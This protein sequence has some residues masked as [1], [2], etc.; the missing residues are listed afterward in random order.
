LRTA[1]LLVDIATRIFIFAADRR[2]KRVEGNGLAT[3]HSLRTIVVACIFGRRALIAAWAAFAATSGRAFIVLRTIVVGPLLV[4]GF[5]HVVVAVIFVVHIVA[6]L[7]PLVFE[8]RAA[9]AQHAKIVV[10]ELEVIFGLH[11]VTRQ[12]RITRHILV[13]FQQL[14]GI[15]A[16]AIVLPVARLAAHVRSPLSPA[17]ATAATLSIV[18]QS[19]RP[20]EVVS[21][22]FGA[23]GQG[24]ATRCS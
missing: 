5:D 13:F 17:A 16:L 20:Y 4:P 24:S 15:S 19:L 2:R 14:G 7:A 12:L 1:R 6:A 9:F 21:V 22:P 10:G 11:A 8:A 23:G 18:D 3:V